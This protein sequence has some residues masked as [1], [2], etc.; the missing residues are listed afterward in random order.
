MKETFSESK[1]IYILGALNQL[2][3]LKFL[4]SKKFYPENK[5]ITL[6]KI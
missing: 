2:F 4:I 1:F 5:K 6:K 3:F